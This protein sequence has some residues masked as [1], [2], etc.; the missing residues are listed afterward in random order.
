MS[1]LFKYKRKPEDKRYRFVSLVL[2]VIDDW[3]DFAEAVSVEYP[4]ECV[5]EVEHTDGTYTVEYDRPVRTV[6]VGRDGNMLYVT[7][8]I[9]RARLWLRDNKGMEYKVPSTLRVEDGNAYMLIPDGIQNV[10]LFGDK[11][12]SRAYCLTMG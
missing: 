5:L 10:V 4:G 6:S 11:Y 12:F 7:I 3:K 9:P 2:D 1:L 8:E